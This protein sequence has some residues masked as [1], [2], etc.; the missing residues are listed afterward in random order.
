MIWE[1]PEWFFAFLLLPLILVVQWW[2]HKTRRAPAMIFSRNKNLLALGRGWK[3]AGRYGIYA[4]QFISAIL[5][6]LA[7]A[8][9]Q[10]ENITIEEKVDG[11]DIVLVLDISS[12]MLAEDLKPNRFTAVNEVAT[13]FVQRRV[14]DRIGLVVFA[15]ESITLV[16][17]TLD[18]RLVLMQ[19]DQMSMDILQDGTAIG[20]GLATAANRLEDS[21]AETRVIV[22][23]TDGENNAGEIDPITS[24]D[25]AAAMGIRLYTIG[26]STGAETAPYPIDDPVFGRRY[27]NIRVEID[28]PML[29]EMAAKTGGRYFRARDNRELE[30][31]YNEIDQL[32]R[33]QIDEIVYRDRVD[34]YH[35]FLFP[36]VGLLLLSLLLDRTLLRTDF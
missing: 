30:A 33:S 32:E 27:Y 3:S 36:G 31:V 10:L 25:I 11:I 28:E 35:L 14:H 17:P 15:R 2:Y 24:S 23:L 4:G 29:T 19:L 13:D 8:R 1:N 7:L 6:I 12:S 16:P 20:M 22:L 26:A 34:K 9:P 21:D 18:H 5:I